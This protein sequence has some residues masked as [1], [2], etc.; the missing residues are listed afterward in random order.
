MVMNGQE[1]LECE[2]HLDGVRLENVSKFKHL[3]CILD[4]SGIEWAECSRKV[5][6]VRRVASVI[7][8]LVNA[9]DLQIECARILHKT[10]LVPV[11]TFGTETML[12]EERSRIRAVQ[13]DNLRGVL[14]IRRMDRVLNAQIRE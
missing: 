5:A 13:M 6:S 2:F 9:R 3:G 8:S 12:W 11:L 4:K 14:G 1:G 10:F 7:R